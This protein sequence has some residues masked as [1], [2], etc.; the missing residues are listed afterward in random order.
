MDLVAR[1]GGEEFVILLPETDTFGAIHIAEQ[2][3][4]QVRAL[5]IPHLGSLQG[6]VTISAGVATVNPCIE[7]QMAK[8][9][10][11]ADQALYQAKQEGRDRFCTYV[12]KENL[13]QPSCLKFAG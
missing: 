12:G 11:M 7:T 3:C 5:A 6:H 10:S 4:T 9:I 8:L 13:S 1:Y 2:I